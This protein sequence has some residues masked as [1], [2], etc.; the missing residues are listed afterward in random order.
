MGRL[1][2]LGVNENIESMRWFDDLA[3]MVTFRQ[4]DPLYAIDLTDPA[5]PTLLGKLKIPGFSEYLHPLGSDRL[6]GIGQGPTGSG[7]RGWGA[8]LGLF[9]V[10]DLT[11]VRRI[12]V[13]SYGNGTV[14]QAASDPRQVTWL[15]AERTLLTVISSGS[16]ARTGSVSVVRLEG[17]G[18]SQRLVEVEYGHEVGQVR[19]V[20]LP[21]GRV[22]LVTGDDATF[23]EL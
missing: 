9:D 2:K 14:A 22:V 17:G 1:D 10:T 20:P 23:F 21:D 18:L 12:D 6:I 4:V 7:P 11:D 16:G 5:T 8:Q 13:L 3:I 15:P 19:T